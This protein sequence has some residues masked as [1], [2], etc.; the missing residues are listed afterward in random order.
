MK[1][2]K[3][4]KGYKYQLAESCSV[5]VGILGSEPIRTEFITLR[6]GILKIAAGYAWD[7]PSGPTVDSKSSMRASLVHDALYQL[8]RQK[9]LSASDRKE[10]DDI[11]YKI[12]LADG[13]WKWRAYLWH[14]ELRKF[15]KSAASPKNVKR[16]HI[17][18]S[19]KG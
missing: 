17:A 13:M 7:G 1:N 14:R 9:R 2:I 16:V 18:P 11:F 10:A 19:K 5:D 8:I 12:C 6:L 4:R 15:A 3:Y